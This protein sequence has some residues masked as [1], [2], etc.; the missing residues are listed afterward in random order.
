[1]R[2]RK[3][4]Y[5]ILVLLLASA[6]NT[7]KYVPENEYLLNKVQV[8]T[9]PK[10][11]PKAE[12]KAYVRQLPNS[13]IL[14][15]SFLKSQLGIYNWSGRDT[16]KWI[17]WWL[18]KIGE[19]PV[20]YDPQLSQITEKQ[21]TKFFHNRGY[22]NAE[23]SSEV[24]T[25]KEKIAEVSYNITANKPYRIREYAVNIQH[26]EL[27]E[28]ASD[29]IRG[30]IKSGNLFDSDVL[31]EERQR[32]TTRFRNLGY[33]NFT[34]DHL[35]YYADSTL[36][37][38]QADLVLEARN[39]TKAD[40]ISDA[41]KTFQKYKIRK[42]HFYSQMDKTLENLTEEIWLDTLELENYE[43]IYE[44][45][46]N[47]RPSVLIQSTHIIPGRV[48][49]DRAVERTYSSINT[50]S[51]VRYMDISFQEV[52]DDELD[53]FIVLTPSKLQ[54]M[55]TDVE[56]TYSAGYWGFGG[57]VNY[58][59][60]NIFKGSETLSLRGRA[61]YEY[62]GH[63]QHAYELGGDVSLKYPTFLLP[64][65][66]R[67][68]KRRVRATTEI[69]GSYSFRKR[70]KEYTGIITG[71]GFKYNWSERLQQKH[72]FDVLNI[73]YVYYPYISPEYRDYLSTSPYFVYNFQNHLI[74]SMGYK[75]SYSGFRPFQP[76]RNYRTLHYGIETAGNLLYG[77]NN[78]FNS[79]KEEE[80]E[81]YKIFGIRYAQYVKSDI[82]LSYHQIFDRNTRIVYHAG[83]GITIPYGNSI[84]APFE[85]RYFSGGANSV[86]GWTAYQ[87]GPGSYKSNGGYINYNTQ[88]GDIKID[89]NMEFRSKLFWKLEGALFLD[90]GNV[91]TLREYDTQPG[92]AF[93]LSEFLGQMGVAYGAGLRADF[94]FFVLRLDLG[95]KLHDPTL[96]RIDCWRTKPTKNDYAFNLAIG[97]PF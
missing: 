20:I 76:L 43:F 60:R 44:N 15:I 28:I 13:E 59:H 30:L 68:M 33:F 77:M 69:N 38:H 87:L 7:T 17:N 54:S 36:N 66:T 79:R 31:D 47:I 21:I 53:A 91:W 78:L 45:K 25:P 18:K 35:E 4:L 70:P 72:N 16:T 56:G 2:V 84:L 95:I 65:A 89:L 42:V 51:A 24:K 9:D 55:S 82:S 96:S 81:G 34:K 46:R 90:M 52:S 26:P 10:I 80:E 48:Y 63:N 73:S 74:M 75:G 11:I 41:E 12:I 14:G 61:A 6:C 57:N 5:I 67:D 71:V 3:Y 88:M 93:K 64:F 1:M 39:E 58:G 37:S 97:Y 32:V 83:V 92:G 94:S 85:K 62:Q 50:L 27:Y 23:V 19:E 29:S 40:D 49:S 22:M 8:N 86:R